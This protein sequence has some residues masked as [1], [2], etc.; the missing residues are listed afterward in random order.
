MSVRTQ[1]RVARMLE[2]FEKLGWDVKLFWQEYD[3]FPQRSREA[4]ETEIVAVGEY[5]ATGQFKQLR[6]DLGGVSDQSANTAI[7]RVLEH[8]ARKKKR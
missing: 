8:K 6:V 3:K 1:I 5:M 7:R 2:V 4:T